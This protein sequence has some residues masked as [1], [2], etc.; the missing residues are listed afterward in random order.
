MVTCRIIYYGDGEDM[1]KIGEMRNL[2]I[3]VIADEKEVI[4]EGRVE[5]APKEI[6]EMKYDRVETGSTMVFHIKT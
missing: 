1:V 3:K 5:E 2:D 4:Y 6:R